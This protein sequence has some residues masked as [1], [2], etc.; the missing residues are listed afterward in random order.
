MESE[1]VAGIEPHGGIT[2][3]I[4][5]TPKPIM[6]TLSRVFKPVVSAETGDTWI[7]LQANEV[8]V[9]FFAPNRVTQST[10]HAVELGAA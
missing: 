5:D 7:N 9:T 1:Q 4:F 2:V 10:A 6:D 3:S 8:S